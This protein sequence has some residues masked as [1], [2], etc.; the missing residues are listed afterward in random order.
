M[1]AYTSAQLTGPRYAPV[2]GVGM[3]GRTSKHERG[4]F[5][6]TANLAAGD[7]IDLFTLPRNA[8]VL[9]GFIKSDAVDT[10]SAVTYNIGITG[11]PAL[12]F[13]GSIVGRTG[14]GVDSAMAATGRDYV[15]TAKTKVTLTI[16]AAPA[17]GA[18]GGNIVV[19]FDYWVEEPA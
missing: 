15:T 5:A 8:R 4:S 19:I 12:F 14:G 2:S 13:N 3:G 16:G 7:T 1:T 11:T 10:G 9:G 6:V 17:G 18:T